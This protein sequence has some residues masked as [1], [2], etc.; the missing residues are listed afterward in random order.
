MNSNKP[1][2]TSLNLS[3]LLI[4][5]VGGLGL[6]LSGCGG[7]GN[8]DA[9]SFAQVVDATNKEITSIKLEETQG[10]VHAKGTQQFNVLGLKADT[11]AA[12]IN[13]NAKSS[14]QLSDASFGSI[15]KTGLFTAAGKA[16]DFILSV[17]YAGMMLDQ[18]VIVTDANLSS[19]E[20][21]HSTGSVDVCKDTSFSGTA[22]FDGD[23]TLEY[24][25]EWSFSDSDSKNFASF[26]DSSKALMN[27]HK[28]GKVKVIASGTNNSDQTITSN[29]LDIN[30]KDSL[31][32]LTFT[33]SKALEM[34]N[35]ETAT[36]KVMGKYPSQSDSNI[37]TNVSFTSDNSNVLTID[38]AKGTITAKSGSLNGTPVTLT[39]NCNGVTSQLALKILT[40]ELKSMA[41]LGPNSD[42]ATEELSVSKNSSIEPRVKITYADTSNSTAFY[43]GSD[44]EW[45]I[46]KNLSD[47]FSDSEII[48]NTSSGKLT[49]KDISL[50]SRLKLTLAARLKSES[51]TTL[52]G[53][54]GKELKDTIV[55][56]VNI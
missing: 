25:L 18:K 36:L 21:S 10:Y 7:G 48:L 35:G 2:P 42:S 45:S 4:L 54:D 8:S 39:A 17:S 16:G 29:E 47:S 26:K 19:I 46:D 28:S 49:I 34:R 38:S 20:I 50:S 24:P 15:S 55:V 9:K 31:V 53:S 30:I 1:M 12:A 32:S 37:T 44:L 6:S 22:R 51:G 43:T 23:L 41:I 40:P 13:L 52:L 11:S 5:S 33:S 56:Y 14:W 3:L 27:T